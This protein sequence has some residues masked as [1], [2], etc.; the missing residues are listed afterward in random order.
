MN[1]QPYLI[2]P[3]ATGLDKELQPW[4]LPDDAYFELFDG[5]VYRGVTNKRNGYAGYAIGTKSS[6][7]E[8]RIVHTL[9][10]I[11][12]ATGVIDGVNKVFTF[13]FMAPVARGSIT[14]NGNNP[15]QVVT[16]N[17]QSSFIGDIDPIGINTIN[18]TIG[19]ATVTFLVAP[20]IASTVLSIASYHPGLPGMGVMRFYPNSN[21]PEMIVADTRY[22]NRYD[23]ATDR[24]VDIS[25]AT[26]YTGD[27]QDFWSW[28]N[29]QNAASAP[30]LLFSNGAAG[31][32]IQQWDG[33]TV[34]DYA[35]TSATITRLNARQI[36]EFQDRLI[37]F[38]TYET[39]AGP[40]TTFYPRRIRISGFGANCDNFD[41][42]AAGA[43]FID[44]PDNTFF[45]GA[46][47]NRDD[48]L[49]FTESSVWLLK[50]TGNDVTPFQL[51][52]IDGSRG[53]KAAFSVISYL[54]RTMAA[55]PRGLIIVDG[56]TVTRMDDNLPEFAF[57]DIN[58][59]FFESCFSGFIDEDRDVYTLYPSKG[60]V[61]PP[62][63]ATGS[64]DRILVSNFE[65]DNSAIYRLP[66]SCMGNFEVSN[67]LIWA[68]LTPA[69]GYNNWDDLAA[70]FG[71][72]N[73]FP[74]SKS[75]PVAIGLGHKGEVWKL[76]DTEIQDNP[77]PIRN[78][79]IVA[80]GD[81]DKLQVTTD[82]NNYEIG[83]YIFFKGVLG[84][85]QVNDKQGFIVSVDTD[86]NIFTI[87]MNIKTNAFSSY[88]SG[89]I[90]SRCVPFEA[91][92][93]KFNPFAN[94]D[95][96]VKCGWIY[97]YVS[98]TNTFL[99]KA[100]ITGDQVPETPILEIDVFMN[101]WQTNSDPT[102]KYQLDLSSAPN[103]EDKK[104][105]KIWINQVAKFLQ[106]RMKNT[107][108]GTKIKIHA[109][110]P[111]FLPTGRLI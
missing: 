104:W 8:S 64:S 108:A 42:T 111:G 94:M 38:Q 52:K 25:P 99:T 45:F 4:L 70:K 51:K 72:W 84:M 41:S 101:D 5:Y 30:R 58:N 46:A 57:N 7:V 54:N 33:T 69:N 73:A 21:E 77:L 27:F 76:T 89:G 22:V 68:D 106:F 36:F 79:T 90:A 100:S 81:E 78:I 28:V 82:W 60:D 19:A 11:T 47:F 56:Y 15:V 91:L 6:Y 74:F 14:I 20:A 12:P 59:E 10:A 110:M 83:D 32:V 29:Y 55:S 103:G 18:Y 97:F 53:S 92:S 107:Q 93:K 40:V 88:T 34:T 49:F 44:I 2:A 105:I 31:D 98:C 9:S 75:V 66:L 1:Y 61:R 80:D 23:R 86:F 39:V 43:G 95:K 102:F 96:K 37:L 16:D 65:E 63:V 50:Y 62:L 48:L 85:T 24:L 87:Q 17:S 67:T 109:M 26:A 13:I 35:Y 71:D 3:S